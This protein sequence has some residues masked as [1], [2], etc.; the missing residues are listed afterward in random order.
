MQLS[1]MAAEKGIPSVAAARSTTTPTEA[2][3]IQLSRRLKEKD[4]MRDKP[5]KTSITIRAIS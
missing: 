5:R 2:M 3:F 4:E 1:G